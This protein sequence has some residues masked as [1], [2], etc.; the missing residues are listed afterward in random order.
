MR[1]ERSK[2][3]QLKE[4]IIRAGGRKG[5]PVKKRIF[6]LKRK[7]GQLEVKFWMQGSFAPS[8]NLWM[9]MNHKKQAVF[10]E[11]AWIWCGML[12]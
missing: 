3:R 12:Q 5:S 7:N 2:T 1:G 9:V 8:E 11:M 10:H 6:M 4:D